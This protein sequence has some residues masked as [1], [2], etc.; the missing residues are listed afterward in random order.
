MT[1]TGSESLDRTYDAL[2]VASG[3]ERFVGACD[4]RNAAIAGSDGADYREKFDD[5]GVG[6]L[7][8]VLEERKHAES[9]VV[10]GQRVFR[11]VDL[12][13]DEFVRLWKY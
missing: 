8:V 1:V 2:Y 3:C 9:E 10:N 5:S 6:A 11:A 4:V 7:L 13:N 12:P